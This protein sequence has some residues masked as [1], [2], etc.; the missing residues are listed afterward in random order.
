M[1]KI[2]WNQRHMSKIIR[3]WRDEHHHV[4]AHDTTRDSTLGPNHKYVDLKI[5]EKVMAKPRDDPDYEK[6]TYKPW[7]LAL[8]ALLGAA[9]SYELGNTVYYTPSVLTDEVVPDSWLTDTVASVLTLADGDATVNTLLVDD[10]KTPRKMVV[11][12]DSFS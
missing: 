10:A 11:A 1:R 2:I 7:K 12:T 9:L 3:L 4:A 8:L 6:V 5:L